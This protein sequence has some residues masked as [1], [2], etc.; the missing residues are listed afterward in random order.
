MTINGF[1][2]FFIF[3]NFFL[4]LIPFFLGWA[5]ITI[6]QRQKIKTLPVK[7]AIAFIWLVWLLFLPNAPY[8]IADLRHISGF[9]G[10]AELRICVENAWMPFFLFI[11]A[12]IGWIAFVFALWQ[13]KT[14]LGFIFS[15]K[16]ANSI[17]LGLI[18]LSSLGLLLGL[19]NRF[20]SWDFF[21]EPFTVINGASTYFTDWHN[22]RNLFLYTIMFYILYFLGSALFSDRIFKKY[23]EVKQTK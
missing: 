16:M 9:C 12:I 4:L 11:Y 14:F 20:N 8:L 21:T 22:F 2:V 3:W 1:P 6:W 19:V 18:P 17:I 5:L 15:D 13:M 7:A 23:L 10:E